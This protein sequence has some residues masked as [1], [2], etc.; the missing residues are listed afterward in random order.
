MTRHENAHQQLNPAHLADPLA[1][2]ATML[3][4]VSAE[5]EQLSERVGGKPRANSA[6]E[7]DKFVANASTAIAGT[8]SVSPNA[9]GGE[10]GPSE[11]DRGTSSAYSLGEPVDTS[12]A[13][14]SNTPAASAAG[15]SPFTADRRFG[16]AGWQRWRGRASPALWIAGTVL[17]LGILALLLL[18]NQS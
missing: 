6:S 2:I 7:S 16:L 9:V 5:L 8:M 18:F 11:A 14:P 3:A 12:F 1:R 4:E 15:A 13:A 10:P 17:L